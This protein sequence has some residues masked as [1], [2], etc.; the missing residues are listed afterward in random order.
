MVESMSG[1]PTENS[2]PFTARWDN[3][4]ASVRSH[5]MLNKLAGSTTGAKPTYTLLLGALISS[6]LLLSS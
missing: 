2:D 6:L 4:A 1:N 3:T 5:K